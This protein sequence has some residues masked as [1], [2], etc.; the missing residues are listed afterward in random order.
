MLGAAGGAVCGSFATTAALRSV[1]GEQALSGRSR[2][3]GCARPLG[4]TQTAPLVS[5]VATGG[6]CR[7]CGER[8]D[9]LHPLG[10]TAGALIGI[11]ACLSP[12]GAQAASLASLGLVLLAAAVIDARS[13]RLPNGLTL[14]AAMISAG[15]ALLEGHWRLAEGMVFAGLLAAAL[16]TVR[17]LLRSGDGGPALGLGDVKLIAALSLWAGLASAW[18]LAV[19]AILTLIHLRWRP[20]ADRRAP[21]GPAIAAAFFVI[22]G[23]REIG[24][25][26]AG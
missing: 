6:A 5:Y 13:R 19:A 12:T 20:S 3:D 9:P 25:W 22:G 26:P 16:F 14:A 11:M 8:I 17:R 4:F 21:F 24:P 18:A 23:A 10:E 15:M 1:R 7:F 2:C